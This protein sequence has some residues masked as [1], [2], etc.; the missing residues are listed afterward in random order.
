MSR[1]ILKVAAPRKK[2]HREFHSLATASDYAAALKILERAGVY[3]ALA[4][5]FDLA[6]SNLN[7]FN[8]LANHAATKGGNAWT[9][10]YLSVAKNGFLPASAN[11]MT[12]EF[13][14]SARKIILV[15]RTHEATLTKRMGWKPARV[16]A[17][18]MPFYPEYLGLKRR[19]RICK[20]AADHAKLGPEDLRPSKPV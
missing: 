18:S 14:D 5:C 2:D 20:I 4:S 9:Q 15:A 7:A 13:L 12:R 3:G 17:S 16:T 8:G 10:F 6:R 11:R 19:A 1:N